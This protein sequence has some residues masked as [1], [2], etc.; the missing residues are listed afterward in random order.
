[1]DLQ[2]RSVICY[3]VLRHKSNHQIQAKLCLVYGKD[4]L[5]LRTVCTWTARFRSKKTSVEDDER[6]G[7]PSCDDFS[8]AI[9]D[10]L[11]RNPYASCHD[12]AKGLFVPRI[13]ILRALRENGLQ[14]LHCKVGASRAIGRAEGEKRWDLYRDTR[15]SG[16]ARPATKE[17][18]YYRW[19]MLDLLK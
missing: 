7:R 13:T 11:E 4:A 12:I 1:M 17:S 14:I 15:S 18:Y 19:R 5:C 8:S 9:S 16:R 2:Q 3:Y 6:P 10:Y